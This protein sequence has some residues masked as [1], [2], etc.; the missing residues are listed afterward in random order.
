ME[1]YFAYCK[2]NIA[3][4]NGEAL[5]EDETLGGRAKFVREK[6]QLPQS[7]MA[8]VLGISLRNWQMME[9]D[10]SLPSGETLLRFQL[11]GINPGWVLTG[12][13]P[14]ILSDT[15]ANQAADFADTLSARSKDL[16]VI[17]RYDVQAAAGDGLIPVSENA[18]AG[19]IS[20]A[21]SLLRKIGAQPNSC[22]IL[23]SKGD[24]MLPT[25]PG[26]SLLVVD[27]SKTEVDDETVF[28]F[29][30]GPGIKVKRAVWRIDGN[31]DLVSDNDKYPPETYGPD[32]AD[33][34]AP[35]GQVMLVLRQP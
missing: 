17:P 9:R 23:E 33:E 24:S 18:D 2:Q 29:R 34:I 28:V 27:R 14:V 25:I 21:R 16:V 12:I 32:R 7:K 22:V 10:E 35:I 15:T 31:L 3:P 26:G 19:S 11:I 8:E 30:V 6:M 13:G 5:S 20:I 1:Q 4:Y